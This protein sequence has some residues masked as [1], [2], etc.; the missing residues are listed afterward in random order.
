MLCPECNAVFL[1]EKYRAD[2]QERVFCSAQCYQASHATQPQSCLTCQQPFVSKSYSK[3]QKYCCLACVPK[4]GENNPNYGK[5]H[6]GMF[7]HAAQFRLFLSAQ[8]MGENNP[9]WKGG[10]P[11]NGHWAHQAW[12]SQWAKAN[13]QGHCELCAATAAN[14]H[15]V[16]PG[17]LFAPRLLM[18]FRQNLVMLCDVHQRQAVEQG[19][20]AL[21]ARTP[22]LAP[23]ADR[24]PLSILEALEQGGLVSS[25]LDGCDYSPLGNVGELIHSGHWLT[26]TA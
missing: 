3:A 4:L 10:S 11:A 21:R 16:V 8:R 15:H 14:V 26:C 2:A 17:R 9:A 7:Q 25:P 13:L 1:A 19:T 6:P 5:R 18:Q 23:F 24:L 12:V 20:P 22:R